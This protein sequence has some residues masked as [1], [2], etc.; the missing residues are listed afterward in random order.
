MLAKVYPV[1]DA[2]FAANQ[3]AAGDVFTIAE[4]AAAPALRY[5][6]MV[7]PFEQHG[8]LAAYWKRLSARPSYVRVAEEAAP[9]LAKLTGKQGSI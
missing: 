5:C 3:W 4:C 9:Y 6:E 1:L 7:Y 8:H 2:H